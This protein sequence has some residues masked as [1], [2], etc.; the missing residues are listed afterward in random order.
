VARRAPQVAQALP[1]AA[2]SAVVGV[3]LSRGLA[4]RLQAARVAASAG[5]AAAPGKLAGA[6]LKAAAAAPRF[7]LS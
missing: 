5:R 7:G 3:L 1:T 4:Q 6:E 2:S